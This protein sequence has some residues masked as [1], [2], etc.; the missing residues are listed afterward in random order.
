MRT[1]LFISFSDQENWGLNR[2]NQ[3]GLN[4]TT[5]IDENWRP[6]LARYFNNLLCYDMRKKANALGLVEANRELLELVNTYKPE[7]VIYPCLFDGLVT[8]QSLEVIRDSGSRIAGLF[9]DDEIFFEQYT[10]YL[11]PYLDF[12]ITA[13]PRAVKYYQQYGINA[14][15]AVPIPMDTAIFRKLPEIEKCFDVTFVGNPHTADRQIWLDK[16]EHIKIKVNTFGGTGS[17]SKIHYLTMVKIFNQSRIN[18]NF[19]KHVMPDGQL[20]PQFKGRI[21]EVTLSGG[22]LLCEYVP[23]IETC[24][25]LDKE[26]V[27]FSNAIEAAEK[28]KYYLDH[29]LERNA[30]ATA[31]Y[32]RAIN[33]YSGKIIVNKIFSEILSREQSPAEKNT[34]PTGHQPNDLTRLYSKYY[35]R[36]TKALLASSYPLRRQWLKTAELSLLSDPDNR[37]IRRIMLMG[38]IFCDPQPFTGMFKW[39]K[40]STHQWFL[41]K[42]YLLRKKLRKLK[43]ETKKKHD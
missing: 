20:T 1:A 3:L 23:G 16:F 18:L 5:D 24:F 36:W 21:F 26:I 4:C 33:N 12:F 15:T 19:S 42:Y 29:E 35:C 8:L 9:F 7:Y 37:Q 39:I 31:G 43:L 34:L 28:I 11:L 14:I 25:T 22:F 27:C 40:W 38:K 32:E 2:K 41:K 17:Q 13:S 30:I 10:K 6:I